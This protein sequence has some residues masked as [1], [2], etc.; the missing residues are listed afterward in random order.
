MSRPNQGLE[1]SEV[2]RSPR[3]VDGRY[4]YVPVRWS[5]RAAPDA[6]GESAP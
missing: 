6:T 2:Y 3:F 5:L 1:D 4:A